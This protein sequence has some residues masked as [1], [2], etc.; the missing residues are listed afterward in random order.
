MKR[1]HYD[2]RGIKLL[3]IEEATP[4]CGIDFCDDCGDCL[5]CSDSYGVGRCSDGHVWVVYERD[6]EQGLV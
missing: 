5:V 3:R 2:S 1:F 6:I 4:V